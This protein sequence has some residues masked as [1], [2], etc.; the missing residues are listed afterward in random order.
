M[1]EIWGKAMRKAILIT[2][3]A[4]ANAGMAA[5]V[6]KWSVVDGREAFTIYADTG[7]IR[8]NGNL[9]QMWDMTD[10]KTGKALGGVKKSQSTRMER[11][12]ECSKQQIRM[13]YVSWHA[14]NMG[15]GEIVGSDD[16]AGAW[17]P[18]MLGTIGERL[19]R[20]ACGTENA[21]RL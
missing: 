18:M 12:Y 15:G 4:I 2:L 20:I 11:E 10:A 1:R 6:A 8:R 13:L 17:Q 14:A 21:R 9:A 19:W 16:T 5:D 3:L 7:T